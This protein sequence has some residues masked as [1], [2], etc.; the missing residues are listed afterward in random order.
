MFAG[1]TTWLI[2][3]IS[4][5]T[6]GSYQLFKPAMDTRFSEDACVTHDGISHP[7][8]N[9]STQ[10][11]SLPVLPSSVST[12]LIDE[13]NFF[14]AESLWPVIEELISDQRQVIGAGL[15]YDFAKQPFGATL[16]LSAKA[17]QFLELTAQ[18]DR[19]GSAAQYNY[20]KVPNQE[21]VLLG[22]GDSYGACCASCWPLLQASSQT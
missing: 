11:P 15:L 10:E 12:V 17:N 21:Q 19:C 7:A 1:K 16:P 5:L 20:R 22:A 3:K 6:P 13:L 9:L 14:S 2:S 8:A 18:C 4:E